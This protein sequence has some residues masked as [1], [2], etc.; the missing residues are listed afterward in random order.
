MTET[1]QMV[2]RPQ[3]FD[4]LTIFATMAAKST[5][6]PKDY[7]GKPENIMLAIQMGSELG[8]APMQ[9][10]QNIA[11]INGRPSVWG[12][13]MLALVKAHP[14]FEDARETIAGEGDKMVATCAIKRRSQ[15]PVVST[16]SVE[17][18]KRSGLWGKAGPWQSYPKRMLQMRARG[19]AVRDA[20]PDTLRGLISTEEARDIPDETSAARDD[21]KGTTIDASSAPAPERVEPTLH[22]RAAL[23]AERILEMPDTAENLAKATKLTS[24]LLADLRAAGED[25]EAARLQQTLD[26]MRIAITETG[27]DGDER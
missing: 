6:V 25:H 10:L 20:F 18:A 26:D 13:A 21:F 7:A 12:D 14:D 9:S 15:S 5:L 23:A 4:Q 22:E 8:L 2:L 11:V 27:G 16:F 1:M 24:R 17:D 19:F 3:T